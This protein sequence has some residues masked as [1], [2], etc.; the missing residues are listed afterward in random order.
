MFYTCHLSPQYGNRNNIFEIWADKIICLSAYFDW[1]KKNSKKKRLAQCKGK[2]IFKY[3]KYHHIY[4]AFICCIL[5]VQEKITKL[6]YE[7]IL[8]IHSHQSGTTNNSFFVVFGCI[9]PARVYI[10][11]SMPFLFVYKILMSVHIDLATRIKFFIFNFRL[12]K[13]IASLISRIFMPNGRSKSKNGCTLVPLQKNTVVSL[14]T[15]TLPISMKAKKIWQSLMIRW[16]H[17][18]IG[19][20]NW[21]WQ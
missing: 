21:N 2:K 5:L 19:H 10:I 8:A 4:P 3:D 9:L 14:T 18:N 7:Y 20:T 17:L 11:C 13:T 16:E 12:R 15:N 1:T 6:I